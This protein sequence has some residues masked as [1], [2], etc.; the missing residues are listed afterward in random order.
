MGVRCPCA[1]TVLRSLFDS[2]PNTTLEP[3]LPSNEPS[4]VSCGRAQ[5]RSCARPPDTSTLSDVRA[6]TKA[7]PSASLCPRGFS[8]KPRQC[9]TGVQQ[10]VV[11]MRHRADVRAG[12][13]MR[14]LTWMRR[15]PPWCAPLALDVRASSSVQNCGLR[16]MRWYTS[17][18]LRVVCAREDGTGGGRGMRERRVGSDLGSAHCV[19]TAGTHLSFSIAVLGSTRVARV[20]SSLPCRGQSSYWKLQ[21]CTGNYGAAN[22]PRTGA[23]LSEST[24]VGGRTP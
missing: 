9:A 14:S 10:T 4:A 24:R 21:Q 19:A 11:R 2:M 7:Q 1:S 13:T 6:H 16:S 5:R 20:P 12:P 3:S 8:Q 17:W 22:V 23:S 15:S 18:Y